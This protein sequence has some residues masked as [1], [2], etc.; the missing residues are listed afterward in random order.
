MASLFSVWPP[1]GLTRRDDGIVYRGILPH[2]MAPC[3]TPQQSFRFARLIHD[4]F[5]TFHLALFGLV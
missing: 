3:A 2:G 5:S 4:G 1:S